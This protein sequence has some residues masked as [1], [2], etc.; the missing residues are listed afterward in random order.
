MS[1]AAD[2]YDYDLEAFVDAYT[3]CLL[4]SE[5]DCD[6][7]GNSRGNFDE[8]DAELS[9]E[10]LADIRSDCRDFCDSAADLLRESE[11]SEAQ[12][13]HDFCLTRNGHGAGFWDRGLGPVGDA[14]TD[15]CR[16]Y[17]TQGLYLGDD[18]R[19]YTHG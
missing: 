3:E 15:A 14:L 17:G 10:A 6:E 5:V 8:I 13:G 4:W 19:I 1:A 12:A 18:G 2:G 16:P 11:Q 7:E 9:D